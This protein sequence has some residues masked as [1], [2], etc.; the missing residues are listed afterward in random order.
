VGAKLISSKKTS[1]ITHMDLGT[2]S[3]I[4]DDN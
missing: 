1:H 3:L 2:L 4:Q